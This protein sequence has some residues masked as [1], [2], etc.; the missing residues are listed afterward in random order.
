MDF[1]EIE[2]IEN[3]FIDFQLDY[4][5][6]VKGK[7]RSI[8]KRDLHR[9]QPFSLIKLH[10]AINANK[11]FSQEE[12]NKIIAAAIDINF[13]YFSILLEIKQYP[14]V[15]SKKAV[16]YSSQA[17]LLYSQFQGLSIKTSILWERILNLIHF[18]I[19]SREL[20]DT[21]LDEEI[22]EKE[23]TDENG[24]KIVV[25]E[26]RKR[27]SKKKYFFNKI[28]G[29][30]QESQW[31]FILDYEPIIKEY[32][33]AISNPEKHEF[34]PIRKYVTGEQALNPNA[35]FRNLNQAT[36]AV[37]ENICSMLKK[38]TAPCKYQDQWQ[39]YKK[40]FNLEL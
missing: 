4:I 37:W 34:S 35:I 7:I 11:K 39:I 1:S 10:Q 15:N 36:N 3:K 18:L 38:G 24:N 27:Q 19:F 5:L 31:R 26:I 29:L 25:K 20:K 12:I 2:K 16:D 13:Q 22:R 40:K 8:N 33:D 14:Y 17:F 32:D 21:N 6:E 23:E 28:R 30:D 9:T